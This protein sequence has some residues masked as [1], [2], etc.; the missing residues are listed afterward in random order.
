MKFAALLF[1]SLFVCLL[2]GCSSDLNGDPNEG[3]GDGSISTAYDS[4]AKDFGNDVMKGDWTSAYALTTSEFQ[5]TTSQAEMQ[6]QYDDLVADIVKDD[7]NYKPTMV[8]VDHGSLP[9]DEK[10]AKE[11]YNLK[12][13]PPKD[14]WKAW[15]FSIIGEGDSDGIERGVEAQVLVVEVNGQ[16]KLAHVE[17]AYPD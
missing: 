16:N 14:S 3:S 1:V 12:T 5:A 13:M 15:L 17:F 4:I 7:A 10:E 6:K 9:S 2:A 8:E 11:I